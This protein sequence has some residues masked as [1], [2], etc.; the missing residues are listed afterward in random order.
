M[1]CYNERAVV[2]VVAPG[3]RPNGLWDP[4]S[5]ENM[6][7]IILMLLKVQVADLRT[8]Q[9][10]YPVANGSCDFF[11]FECW[12]VVDKKSTFGRWDQTNQSRLRN[13]NNQSSETLEHELAK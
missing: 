9:T 2:A 8:E 3:P 7:K 10:F 4:G 12:V 6:Y 13:C 5:G 1:Q 11:K